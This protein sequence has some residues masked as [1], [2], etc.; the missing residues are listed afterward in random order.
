MHETVNCNVK[1]QCTGYKLKAP[2]L[3]QFAFG[4][5]GG[6]GGEGICRTF[7]SCLVGVLC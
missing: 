4:G 5:W 1:R 3:E 7:A 2:A 6:G